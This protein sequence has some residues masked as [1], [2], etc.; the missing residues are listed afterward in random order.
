MARVRVRD[1]HW[2]GALRELRAIC[3]GLPGVTE[4]LS[5]GNPT[6]KIG[7]TTFAVL[8][9]YRSASCVWL[10]CR[11]DDREALLSKDGFF[12][13]PYDR[14]GVAVCR[15]ASGIDWPTFAKMLRLS[16]ELAL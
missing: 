11:P 7:R 3:C 4:T 15:V 12:P 2:D 16:Y 1:E 10:L 14:A 9:I 13:A 5:Y 8:D 6:F